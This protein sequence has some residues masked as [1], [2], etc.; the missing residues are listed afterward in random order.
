M[1]DVSYLVPS[2]WQD[3][4]RAI[5]H[6][7]LNERFH[8]L[9]KWGVQHHPD[10]LD[11]GAWLTASNDKKFSNDE[12]VKN[13]LPITWV[14]ILEEE[15]YEAFAETEGPDNGTAKLREELIQCAAVIFAWIEDIDS[16]ANDAA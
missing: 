13:G 4:P 10:S 11:Y 15:L 6:A 12:N 2:G 5:Y 8:Q 14:D 1:T 7:V 9:K 3:A 16:R